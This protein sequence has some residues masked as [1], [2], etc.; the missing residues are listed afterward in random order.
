MPNPTLTLVT[1][2]PSTAELAALGFLT[3]YRGNTLAL[4]R[5]HLKVL[6]AWCAQHGL[7]P[8]ALTKTHL[9]LFR[10]HLE[11][12]RHNSV[13]TVNARLTM[14]R[15]FYRYCVAEE[16]IDKSPA[17]RLAVPRAERDDTRLV[18]L[19]RLELAILLQVSDSYTLYLVFL[20][21]LLGLW[22][23]NPCLAR[24]GAGSLIC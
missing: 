9:E 3:Q 23:S 10:H 17:E 15:T 16:F 21:G 6:Y 5:T 11:Q 20:M 2:T 19:S 7:D 1:T 4:Y 14:I 24:Y 8:L 22:V 12:E 13:G 18:G